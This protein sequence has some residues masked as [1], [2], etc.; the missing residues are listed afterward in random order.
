MNT[1]WYLMIIWH[2]YIYFLI[3]KKLNNL[4]FALKT[5]FLEIF[6]SILVNFSWKLKN[7]KNLSI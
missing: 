2:I 5:L 4:S 3:K 6:F 7:N 1:K